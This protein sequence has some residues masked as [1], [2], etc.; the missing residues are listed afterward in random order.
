MRKFL[1]LTTLLPLLAIAAR[2]ED[3]DPQKLVDRFEQ[4]GG[5]VHKGLRR[6]H[7]KGVCAVG[8]FVGTKDAAKLSSS[9]LFSGKP[10]PV[11]ARFSV[12]GPN[13]LA[14]D[15]AHSPRGMGL[16]F[17]LPGGDMHQM[18][19]LNAPVFPVGTPAAFYEL[20]GLDLPDPATGKADPAKA[21]AFF[22]AHPEAGPFLT[23]IK[24]YAPPPSYGKA[25]YNGLHAFKFIGSDKKE[26]W[27]RFHFV[28][29]DGVAAMT[30]AELAAAP[31]DFLEA[32]LAKRVAKGK[33][34]WD[35][36]VTIGEKDDPVDNASVPWPAGRKEIKAGTLTLTKAGKDEAKACEDIN[37]DPNVVA[38][39]IETSPDP[40]LL[41]R[42]Q[43][44]AES[45]TRRETERQS[46]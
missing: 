35:M 46:N 42:S 36:V 9:A 10:V 32:E 37:F 28:P 5:G 16:Q 43:A 25:Q 33:L 4:L 45:Y 41:Y 2:A 27:V 3:P 1:L 8:S 23:W 30:E 19:T 17:Q 13:P 12:A 6:N 14:P 24:A 26:H 31:A 18:A 39:G 21:G 29:K 38:A 11:T 22:G 20:I 7:A 34:Q 44:Y 40:I 15:A